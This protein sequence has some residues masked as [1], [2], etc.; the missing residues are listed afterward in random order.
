MDGKLGA[1]RVVGENVIIDDESQEAIEH[2][3]IDPDLPT[4]AFQA[5]NPPALKKQ[6]LRN[7]GKRRGFK[8]DMCSDK[9]MEKLMVVM[10]P[11]HV[12]LNLKIAD[13]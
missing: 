2:F 7:F 6:E 3:Q 5:I 10:P 9:M 12:I 8:E 11:I 1:I 13:I 4:E